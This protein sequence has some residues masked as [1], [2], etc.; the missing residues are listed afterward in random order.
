MIDIVIVNWTSGH[1]LRKCIAS[2]LENKN[3]PYVSKVIVIDNDSGD[4][5][6]TDLVDN[7]K[8]EIIHNKKNL[9]FAK[10]C[11]QGF[12]LCK[13][14]FVLLLNPDALLLENTLQDCVAF[15]KQTSSVDILGCCLLNDAGITSKSCSRF[16]SP[17]RFF[18][19]ASGLSKIAPKIFTPATLMTD[20]DHSESRQVDQVM[21]A[22]MFM[23]KDVFDKIGYFDERF[24]V[25]YEELDFS[26]R[27]AKAGG[28]S[29]FSSEIKA[30]HSGE[31]TTTSVKAF[32]LYLSLQSRF[33]YAKKNFSWPGYLFVCLS[34]FPVEFISRFFFLL[35]SGK[36][37]EIKN[38]IRGFKML[39]APPA[40]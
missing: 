32:R 21:G 10:A 40:T 3:E 9:G 39:L 26:L 30:V 5:S 1:Y 2:I 12:R 24:F 19:D 34:T 8:I 22:F 23:R 17:L 4:T 14:D 31:G 29:Y 11:N 7:R 37:G 28:I 25:Y 20:W 16:P 35:L 36:P 33:R 18:Y 38:L 27:L 15:M 13:C 6:A